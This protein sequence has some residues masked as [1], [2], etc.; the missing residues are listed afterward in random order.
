MT[1]LFRINLPQSCDP[2]ACGTPPILG[3]ALIFSEKRHSNR[4]LTRMSLRPLPCPP[5]L[6]LLPLPRCERQ[7]LAHQRCGWQPAV[8]TLGRFR[9]LSCLRL[10]RVRRWCF[11]GA[12]GKACLRPFVLPQCSR[13]APLLLEVVRPLRRACPNAPLT[14]AGC[15]QPTTLCSPTTTTS[16][17]RWSTRAGEP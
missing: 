12:G 8:E 11:V 7:G 2:T 16:P 17:P 14:H 3:T 1:S 10:A 9:L 13:R 4:S 6:L 15:P 5:P